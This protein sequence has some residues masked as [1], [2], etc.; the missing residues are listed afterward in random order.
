MFRNKY[1]ENGKVLRNKVRLVCKG[2]TQ[3]EGVDVDETF[4]PVIRLEIIKMFL[5]LAAH[6]RYKIYQMDVKLGFL[7]E[8]EDR[9]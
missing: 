7:N 8:L 3:I 1:N 6:K 9:H 4:V 5:V 2:Y